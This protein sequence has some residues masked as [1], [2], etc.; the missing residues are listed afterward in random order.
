MYIYIL[1]VTTLSNTQL[2]NEMVWHEVVRVRP[3]R[4]FVI[5]LL[6]V[7]LVQCGSPCI[8]TFKIGTR[9]TTPHAYTLTPILIFCLHSNKIKCSVCACVCAVSVHFWLSF[10]FTNDISS[11][12]KWFDSLLF[13]FLFA[14]SHLNLSYFSVCGSSLFGA[15]VCVVRVLA[16]ERIIRFI[17][18]LVRKLDGYINQTFFKIIHFLF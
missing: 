18:C 6:F 8:H 11:I 2:T 7:R 15:Y 16:T 9:L 4:M 10:K 14:L 17:T 13:F 3:I 5:F 1:L 12:H